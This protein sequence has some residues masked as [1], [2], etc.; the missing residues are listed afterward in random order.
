MLSTLLLIGPLVAASVPTGPQ[1]RAHDPNAYPKEAS[2]VDVL[3]DC[4]VGAPEELFD[5]LRVVDGDTLW[6]ERE[7]ERVKLRLLSI[8]TEEKWMEGGGVSASKPS[9]RYGDQTTGWAQGFFTPRSPDAGPIRVGLRFPDG[10][11]RYDPYGRLLCHVVTDIGI[12]FNL[13]CVRMGFSPYFNK[14]GNSRIDHAAFVDAEKKARAEKRGVWNPGTNSGGK[15]RDYTRLKPWWD[16]RAAA[17]DAFRAKQ[18]DA[19]L[20]FAAADEPDL[21]QAAL[22]AGGKGV[23]VLALVDRFFDE[24]DGSRT[25]LLRAGDRRRAVRVRIEPGDKAAMAE[26]DLEGTKGDFRQNY[27]LV[28]GDLVKGRR[29]FDLVGVGPKDW[30]PAGPEPAVPVEAGAR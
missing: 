20:K 22:D 3:R 19:P 13:L 21:L 14:Y 2:Y 27:V 16:A 18:A 30:R 24:D 4:A 26:V 5:V 10:V 1:Q 12:D 29:G 9:T 23:T 6:I 7:G 8:D 11:E 15:Q 28:T 17:V 25:V